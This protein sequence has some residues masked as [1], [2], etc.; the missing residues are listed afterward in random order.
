M[1]QVQQNQAAAGWRKAEKILGD[2]RC[3][4]RSN[5]AI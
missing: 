4:N 5:F 1:I 3:R 2:S